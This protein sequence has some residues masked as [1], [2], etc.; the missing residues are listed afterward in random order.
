MARFGGEE[1]CPK[2]SAN[3]LMIEFLRTHL[4]FFLRMETLSH[5]F[6]KQDQP[7]QQSVLDYRHCINAAASEFG[8]DYSIIRGMMS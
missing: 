7:F 6:Q 8:G 2:P 4:E 5:L 1:Q 3:S